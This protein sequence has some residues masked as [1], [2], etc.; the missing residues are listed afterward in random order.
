M[1]LFPSQGDWRESDYHDL[2]S[3]T[4]RLIELVEGRI[5][6]VPMPTMKHQLIAHFFC[7]LLMALKAGFAVPAAFKLRLRKDLIREPDVVFLL[8]E[9]ASHV[10]DEYWEKA[11]LVLEVVSPDDPKRDYVDKRKE[12][13]EAGIREYWIVDPKK[14]AVFVLELANGAYAEHGPFGRGD[15]AASVLL[16]PLR[17]P[18]DDLF[19]AGEPDAAG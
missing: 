7:S 17:I 13:A 19:A 12:Y 15:I 6:F 1:T 8:R 5:E 11:D 14:Q 3:R 18:V 16:T 4:N 10:S 9:N 2:T